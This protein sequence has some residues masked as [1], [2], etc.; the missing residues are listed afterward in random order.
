MSAPKELDVRSTS[1]IAR[2]I[3]SASMIIRSLLL[4]VDDIVVMVSIVSGEVDGIP[5]LC[6][7]NN[8]ELTSFSLLAFRKK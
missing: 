5:Q 2:R 6:M 7:K 4:S 1:S 8:Y 3:H